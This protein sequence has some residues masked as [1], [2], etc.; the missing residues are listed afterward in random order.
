MILTFIYHRRGGVSW[1][2]ETDKETEALRATR[3]RLLN[4]EMEIVFIV[5]VECI[6]PGC[7]NVSTG[8]IQRDKILEDGECWG[9]GLGPQDEEGERPEIRSWAKA[10]ESGFYD[11]VS[12]CKKNA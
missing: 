4:K 5:Y 2:R 9:R 6:L 11:L 1:A 10:T 3:L 7:G 8:L 12:R